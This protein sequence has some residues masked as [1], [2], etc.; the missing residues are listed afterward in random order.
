MKRKFDAGSLYQQLLSRIEKIESENNRAKP[1]YC[2]HIK[3]CE[4]VINELDDRWRLFSEAE[5][6][7]II[8][9]QKNV[10]PKFLQWQV[11]YRELFELQHSFPLSGT[12][13]QIKCY[14]SRIRQIDQFFERHRF[15]Y[16]YFRLEMT[17]L[18]SIF[19]ADNPIEN[20]LLAFNLLEKTDV[21]YLFANFMAMCM[22]KDYYYKCIRSY[23][24]IQGDI[25]QFPQGKLSWT[26][27]RI[28]LVEIIYGLHLSGMV[29]NGKAS[30][31]DISKWMEV[32]FNIE[33][34]RPHRDFMALGRRK[35][36]SRTVFLAEMQQVVENHLDNANA[37]KPSWT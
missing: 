35:V 37:Y 6:S 8:D 31:M 29:N 24:T 2:E 26:G 5:L 20:N 3:A 19:F 23:E 4:I 14:S 1:T 21:A 7:D 12:K 33:I 15:Y 27:E 13:D 30:I 25:E 34:S 32:V 17:Q 10:W 22:L 36:K 28:G 18:D 9:F 16:E 11:F